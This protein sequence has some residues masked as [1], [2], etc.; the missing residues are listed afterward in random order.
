MRKTPIGFMPDQSCSSRSFAWEIPARSRAYSFIASSS[1]VN[2]PNTTFQLYLPQIPSWPSRSIRELLPPS[3]RKAWPRRTVLSESSGRGP[4]LYFSKAKSKHLRVLF[5]LGLV[6]QLW[7]GGRR[8]RESTLPKQMARS[9][10]LG[11]L[12]A[13]MMLMVRFRLIRRL[14]RPWMTSSHRTYGI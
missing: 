6:R 12:L 8:C 5:G 10:I 3:S 1:S 2:W 11:I 7:R 14:S 9:A 4:Q 13:S